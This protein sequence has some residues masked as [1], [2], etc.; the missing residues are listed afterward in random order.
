M[1]KFVRKRI[2]IHRIARRFGFSLL[3]GLALSLAL[4]GLLGDRSAAQLDDPT[5]IDQLPVGNPLTTQNA[6]IFWDNVALDAIRTLPPGPPAVARALAMIHTAQ[7]DAWSQYSYTAVGTLLG[8]R[9]RQWPKGDGLDDKT[10]AMTYAAYRVLVDLFPEMVDYI[11]AQMSRYGFDPSITTTNPYTPA[12][13]GNLAAAAMLAYR[14]DDGA[15]QLGD[16]H[17]GAYTDYTGYGPVNSPNEVVDLNRW[18]PL[19]TPNGSFQGRCLEGGSVTVQTYI[20]P[21]WGNVVPF[22][23]N[24]DPITPTAEPAYYPSEAFTQQALDIVAVSA[25]LTEPQK[26]MAEYWADGPSSEFPP[27][28]W[29]LF[30]QVVSLR[31]QHS[32]DDD[33]KLF[34]ALSNANLDAGI[35]AWGIKRDYDSVRPITAIQELFR[36][37]RIRAWAGPYQG[38]RWINGEDWTPYQAA[39]FVSPA[40]AEFVSGH[41]T[42]SAASAEV[43]ATFTGSDAFGYGD[44]F[45]DSEVEYIDK[46]VELTWATFSEAADEAGMSRRYGGIHFA[47]GDVVGRELGR[48][49]GVRVWEKSAGFWR[50]RETPVADL[51]V[52]LNQFVEADDFEQ[53]FS[54]QA[55]RSTEGP[56]AVSTDPVLR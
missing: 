56:P 54:A 8:D 42:F 24:D 12:G 9:Y 35:L 29:A 30:G 45:Q 43:L 51:S 37:Q 41:S 13:L 38:T 21:H 34:L 15:N 4:M 17:P 33:A 49:V 18:Q 2:R 31:D 26:A 3:W 1:L 22:A 40:F 16:R 10:E 27:G 32:L 52:Q 23:L 36:G 14:H 50:G 53:L 46:P 5:Q 48:E 19:A 39:C 55:E 44:R 20:G 25:N 6:V 28:H 11:D 47:P 7:Y